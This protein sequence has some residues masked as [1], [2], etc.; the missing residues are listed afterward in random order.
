MK[1]GR[2]LKWL[3]DALCHHESRVHGIGAV[4]PGCGR[5]VMVMLVVSVIEAMRACHFSH[6]YIHILHLT[7]LLSRFFRLRSIF[8]RLS[9]QTVR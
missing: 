7:L 6:Q 2:A 3:Q 5:G 1:E 9:L 4:A 8:Y